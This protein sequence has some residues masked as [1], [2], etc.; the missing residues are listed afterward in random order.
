MTALAFSACNIEIVPEVV[1]ES[2][3]AGITSFTA[4]IEDDA[5]PA[6]KAVLGVNG[7]SKPQTFWENGDAIS[8]YSSNDTDLSAAAG[9]KFVTTLGENSANA[10]FEWDGEGDAI[11][12]GNY[13]ATYPY[14]SAKRGVNF[15]VDPYRVAAV[16]VPNSQ[17]LAAGTYD[18]N[19]CPMV[20]FAAEGNSSLSFKNAA[21]LLKFRVA[22]SDIVAG[23]IEV[24]AADLISGRFRAD[25]NTTTFE[26]TLE[27]YTASGVA[28]Y[29]YIDFTIDGTTA[30]ATGTDYYVV[31]R[32][33]ALTSDL[34][35]YLNGNLVKTV[36]TSSLASIQRNK[37]YNLGTLTTPAS[38]TEKKLFFDFTGTPQEG[39]PTAS[40]SHHGLSVTY[41]LY[42]SGYSFILTD[43]GVATKCQT[44]WATNSPGKRLVLA[45]AQRYFGLPII[46]NYKL[47][48]V[49]IVSKQLSASDTT[50]KPSMG[51][52][53]SVT[54]DNVNAPDSY[55]VT[56][57]ELQTWAATGGGPYQYDLS[58]TDDATQYYIYAR[59]K[60]AI[61]TL[62]LTYVPI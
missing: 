46:P 6:S 52:T 40:G 24:D 21:A 45:A 41:T 25:V 33:T 49:S 9:H 39:W 15:S 51:I 56:G 14:R 54:Q 61:A 26:P 5:A 47:V 11:P 17:T 59:I 16:D 37:I 27:K 7:E 13:L 60:G 29:N 53:H 20:A 30:L 2:G 62:T 22:E 10:T 50:T 32:P 55:F 34:K 36:N 42:G 23:R 18:R 4:S 38:P 28:Q 3:K 19:A 58:G 31:I 12:S 48:Q 35:F 8:I 57:G 44:Y 43:C 1:T